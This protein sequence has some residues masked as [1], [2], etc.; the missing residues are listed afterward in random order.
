MIETGELPPLRA[1]GG[2][3][4]VAFGA[5]P[6]ASR[7]F[8]A[9]LHRLMNDG[10][11][12]FCELGGGARPAVQ[13]A[14]IR[15]LGLDYTVTDVSEQELSRTP[16]GY[17][18]FAGSALDGPRTRELVARHGPF[19]VVLSRWTAEHLQ[20]GRAFHANVYDMLRPGGT[21][22]HAFPT[23]YALP[24]VFNRV[25][26]NRSTE[27]I[28]SLVKPRRTGKFPAYYSWC[29]GP[30]RRQLARL[31]SL[32]FEIERYVGFFGHSYYRRIPPLHAIH[33]RFAAWEIEHPQPL[34][35]TSALAVLRR[36]S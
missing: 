6:A 36:P 5:E 20:D 12:R 17:R 2:D 31:E 9:T 27:R 15:E 16:E 34:I 13:L 24:F 1:A 3:G 11:R 35:T 21:A 4:R 10:A 8:W 19:D 14:R 28:V 29:R 32:G 7:H 22:V 30:T 23:L 33:Q 18:V 26:D 25:M